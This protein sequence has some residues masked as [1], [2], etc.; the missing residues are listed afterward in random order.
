MTDLGVPPSCP[1]AQPLL[2]NSHQPEQNWADGGTTKIKVNPTHVSQQMN[3]HVCLLADFVFWPFQIPS[4]LEGAK[5]VEGFMRSEADRRGVTFTVVGET[6][7]AE[8]DEHRDHKTDP[9]NRDDRCDPIR[10]RLFA[11]RWM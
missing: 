1:A 4:A 10:T 8:D 7:H 2:A 11:Q 5:G 9:E 6:S 3:H